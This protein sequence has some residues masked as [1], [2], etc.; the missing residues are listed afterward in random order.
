MEDA[1]SMIPNI[2]GTGYSFYGVYD[3]HGGDK[4]ARFLQDKLPFFV[5]TLLKSEAENDTPRNEI[6]AK[7]ILQAEEEF[8]K[9]AREDQLQDGATIVC[10]LVG[11]R[12][13]YVA[14]VGDSEAILSRNGQFS[15]LT[16]VHTPARNEEEEARVKAEGGRVVRGRVGHPHFNPRCFNL[17]VSRAVGD[18]MYKSEEFVEGKN[19]GVVA[20]ADT[21]VEEV[22]GGGEVL[23]LACDGL[24]DVLEYQVIFLLFLFCFCFC[25]YFCYYYCYDHFFLFPLLFFFFPHSL[26]PQ[27]N[28]GSYQSR[29]RMVTIRN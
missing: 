26:S 6:L 25:F 10:A 5:E 24:W 13:V 29:R 28:P 4:A 12:K 3:G 2:G 18:L 7:A 21:K 17:A 20:V 27:K 8:M 9:I 14:N 16:T 23:I 15:L 11:E 1:S 19:S 22:G